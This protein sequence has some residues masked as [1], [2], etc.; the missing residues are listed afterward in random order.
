[1]SKIVICNKCGKAFDKWDE[2]EN[3]HIHGFLGY[4]TKY[5]GSK[6]ELDLCC[7]CL[8]ELAE[9]CK[10]NPITEIDDTY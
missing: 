8:E 5:D 10:I 2:Q 9:H 3:F 7:H 1:M 6:I 4:G